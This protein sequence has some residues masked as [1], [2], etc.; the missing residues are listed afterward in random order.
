MASSLSNALT[1]LS[2][3]TFGEIKRQDKEAV[4]SLI[5]SLLFMPK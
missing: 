1:N 2:V 3:A 4:H 5:K